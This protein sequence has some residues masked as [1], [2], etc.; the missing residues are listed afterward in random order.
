MSRHV[1]ACGPIVVEYF[2]RVAANVARKAVSRYPDFHSG[3][4]VEDAVTVFDWH[5]D[6]ITRKTPITPPI[7]IR[8]MCAGFFRRTAVRTSSSIDRSWRG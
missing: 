6:P 5:S 3:N 7:E 2:A 4:I 8:R 1:A